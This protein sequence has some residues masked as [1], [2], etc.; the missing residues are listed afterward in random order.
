MALVLIFAAVAANSAGAPLEG[1]Q[2]A[3]DTE[4]NSEKRKSVRQDDTASFEE[5]YQNPVIHS[6]VKAGIGALRVIAVYDKAAIVRDPIS[7]TYWIVNEKGD[8][9]TVSAEGIRNAFASIDFSPTTEKEALEA[10][11]LQYAYQKDYRVLMEKPAPPYNEYE[12]FIKGPYGKN[13]MPLEVMEIV[14]APRAEKVG[15]NYVVTFFAFY[16]DYN[17]R[18]QERD[19]R[20]LEKHTVEVGPGLFMEQRESLWASCEWPQM[21][22]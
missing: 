9:F 18:K 22:L 8:K 7:M 15:T 19:I 6:D 21:P 1:R 4:M 17:G 13:I 3:G 2:T 16:C 20:A 5:M 11:I 14:G 12:G 10:A